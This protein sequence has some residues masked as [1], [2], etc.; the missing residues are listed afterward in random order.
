[1]IAQFCLHHQLQLQTTDNDPV[2]AAHTAPCESGV[3]RARHVMS[4]SRLFNAAVI[5]IPVRSESWKPASCSP[6]ARP[7]NAAMR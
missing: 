2:L 6:M 7:L 5:T 4:V 3:L 1:V